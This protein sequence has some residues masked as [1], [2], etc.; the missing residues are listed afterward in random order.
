M[1]EDGGPVTPIPAYKLKGKGKGRA[2]SLGLDSPEVDAWVNAGERKDKAEAKTA[3][4]G[5]AKRVG[6]AGDKDTDDEEEVDVIRREGSDS[7]LDL[8]LDAGAEAVPTAARLPRGAASASSAA[9]EL[10]MQV[11]PRR[12]FAGGARGGSTHGWAPVPSPLRGVASSTA[13]DLCCHGSGA[14]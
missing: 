13:W 3:G 1:D 12:S 8:D 6:F 11:S 5:N 2:G 4:G 9:P 10:A 14:R 7:D